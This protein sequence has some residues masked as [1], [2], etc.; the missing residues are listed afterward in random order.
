MARTNAVMTKAV[1]GT[2]RA[3]KIVWT[4]MDGKR[5]ATLDLAKLSPATLDAGLIHGFSA[6]VGDAAAMSN[7]TVAEKFDSMDRVIANLYADKWHGDR[8][9]GDSALVEAIMEHQPAS[10]REKVVAD[11][12]AMSTEQRNTLRVF[13]PIKKILDR[14][15]ADNAKKSGID[16]ADILAKFK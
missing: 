1:N 13:P 7:A 5:S 14:M 15:A 11:L 16:A 3:A 6:K 9:T 10:K 12:K 8:E 2:G 4:A